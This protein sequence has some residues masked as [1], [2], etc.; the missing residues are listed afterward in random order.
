MR[1]LEDADK[2]TSRSISRANQNLRGFLFLILT[3]QSLSCR[4]FVASAG[5]FVAEHELA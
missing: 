5:S 4:T 1:K 3:A 2:P